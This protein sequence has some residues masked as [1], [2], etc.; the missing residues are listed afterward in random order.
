[1][2]WIE[3]ARDSDSWVGTCEC[4]NEPSGSILEHNAFYKISQHGFLSR[5]FRKWD[6]GVWIGSRWLRIGTVGWVPVNAVM[7]LRVQS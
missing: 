3:V 1:M 6:V 4:G 7:N 2:D 5:I